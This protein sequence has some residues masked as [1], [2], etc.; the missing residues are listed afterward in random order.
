MQALSYLFRA[1]M[2]PLSYYCHSLTV[3]PLP[4]GV[5]G[6]KVAVAVATGKRENAGTSLRRVESERKETAEWRELDG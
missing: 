3:T 6:S 4:G 5:G 2:D 1:E